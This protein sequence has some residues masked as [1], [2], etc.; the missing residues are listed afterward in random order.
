MD[1]VTAVACLRVLVDLSPSQ[2]L[3]LDTLAPLIG[4]VTSAFLDSRWRWP[5]RFA[6]L[7]PSA[8]MLTDPRAQQ[9]DAAELQKLAEE[10]QHKLFGVSDDGDVAL[11]LYEGEAQD[12]ASFAELPSESLMRAAKD[13]VWP[14]A[15]AGTLR[16]ITT[17]GEAPVA[18]HDPASP[19]EGLSLTPQK[20]SAAEPATEANFRGIY[21]TLRQTFVG[22]VVAPSPPAAPMAFSVVDGATHLPVDFADMFD[23]DCVDA[24]A[25]RLA[26]GAFTG[27][28][29]FPI[30]FS[31]MARRSTREAYATKLEALTPFKKSQLAAMVYNVPRSPSF[32]V[33]AQLRQVLDRHFGLMDLFTTDPNFDVESLPNG[34]TNFVTLMLPEAE[35]RV[36]HAAIK[37]FME[38]RDAF[39][40]RQIWPAVSNVRSRAD[41]ATCLRVRVPFVTGLAICSPQAAPIGSRPYRAADLP[42]RPGPSE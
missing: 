33:L 12:T 10:L 7:N 11:L 42:Y 39:K 38:R 19:K 16:Q 21:L 4:K 25:E 18:K 22:C 20:R 23:S 35:D 17:A 8:F 26:T 32:Q 2:R 34:A 30:S 1:F 41:L 37:T 5:R 31:S 13:G 15:L 36:R 14:T 9:L 27:V 3:K 29:A 40:R 24:G 6:L 28:L